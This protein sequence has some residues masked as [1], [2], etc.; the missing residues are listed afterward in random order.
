M[1]GV[2]LWKLGKTRETRET[3]E[4]SHR[5]TLLQYN[6]ISA[7]EIY[8][9]LTDCTFDFFFAKSLRRMSGILLDNCMIGSFPRRSNPVASFYP[10]LPLG[11]SSAIYHARG[12]KLR[13]AS[14]PIG[15]TAATRNQPGKERLLE[16]VLFTTFTDFSTVHRS[17]PVKSTSILYGAARCCMRRPLP[18]TGS[19]QSAL[20]SQG[21]SVARHFVLLASQ[22]WKSSTSPTGDER[23]CHQTLKFPGIL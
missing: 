22:S 5:C 9:L 20:S 14:P 1:T 19:P 18:S 21:F 13:S 10:L 7:P 17:F 3:R 11:A 2:L 23:S 15:S 4:T 12:G 6:S 16:T 8:Q